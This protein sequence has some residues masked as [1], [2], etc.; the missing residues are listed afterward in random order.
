MASLIMVRKSFPRRAGVGTYNQDDM[1]YWFPTAK[2]AQ[3]ASAGGA[4][5]YSYMPS[6]MVGQQPM[7]TQQ[8]TGSNYSRT[9]NQANV[10]QQAVVSNAPS[11]STL[12]AFQQALANASTYGVLTTAQISSY[13]SQANSSTDSALQSLTSQ[14]NQAV[15]TAV[16]AAQT[17]AAASTA[18]A[19][20]T[21]TTSTS[22]W[23]GTTTIFST[24]VNNSTLAIG[25]AIAAALGYFLFAKKR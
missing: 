21:A 4:P 6:S 7:V 11:A 10:Q 16:S 9:Q 25:G 5:N 1:P 14:I 13:Q 18:A 23:D 17:A 22:W 3:Q 8:P 19:A 15:S 24:A 12:S 20:T 2:T